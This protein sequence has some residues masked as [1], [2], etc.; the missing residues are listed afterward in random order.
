MPRFSL[1]SSELKYYLR[2]LGL[3][4]TKIETVIALL[5]KSETV[6]EEVLKELD[7]LP[8]IA[9]RVEEVPRLANLILLLYLWGVKPTD[10]IGQPCISEIL[11]LQGVPL[12]GI[13]NEARESR[14]MYELIKILGEK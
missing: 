9:K 7:E 10:V 12:D 3:N 2:M 4:E 5:K 14:I 8:S 1:R 6:P 13:S 11:T